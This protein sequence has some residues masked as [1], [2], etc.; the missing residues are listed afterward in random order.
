MVPSTILAPSIWI[1]Q[2]EQRQEE[3]QEDWGEVPALPR[4]VQE[5]GVGVLGPS[6]APTV[7]CYN[8]QCAKYSPIVSNILLSS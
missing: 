6:S 7:R 8:T 4:G 5:E 2:V 3:E 1:L